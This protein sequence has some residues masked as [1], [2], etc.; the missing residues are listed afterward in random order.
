MWTL[1]EENTAGHIQDELEKVL[2]P[3]LKPI[4]KDRIILKEKKALKKQ[5]WLRSP[6]DREGWFTLKNVQSK[7]FLT[8]NTETMVVQ[9]LIVTGNVQYYFFLMSTLWISGKSIRLV[10]QRRWFKPQPSVYTG[11]KVL[12]PKVRPR[13]GVHIGVS[14]SWGTL[15]IRAR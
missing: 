7:K 5:Q 9:A 3:E 8:A 10:F 6:P 15:Q 12:H 2:Q 1:P 14:Q 4:I 13:K 11:S